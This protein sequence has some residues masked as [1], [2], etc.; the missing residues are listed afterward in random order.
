MNDALTTGKGPELLMDLASETAC[1]LTDTLDLPLEDA[2]RIG[3]IL[4]ERMVERWAGER[5]YFPKGIWNGKGLFWWDQ[6]ERDLKIYSEFNGRNRA[7]LAAKY[8]ISTRR[9]YQIIEYVRHRLHPKS[10]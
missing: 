10:R 7:E 9:I 6:A 8:N 1:L 3:A 2:Y 4:S 5:L